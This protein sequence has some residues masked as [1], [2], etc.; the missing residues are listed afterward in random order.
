FS[1]FETF[2]GV[3]ADFRIYDTMLS[4][5]SIVNISLCEDENALNSPIIDYSNIR[6][7]YKNIGVEIEEYIDTN[8]FCSKK[9]SYDIIIAETLTYEQS[10]LLCQTL[11]ARM[12]I[13]SDKAQNDRFYKQGLPYVDVCDMNRDD[14]IWL[15]VTGNVESKR[16][17]NDEFDTDLNFTNFDPFDDISWE[18]ANMC[19]TISGNRGNGEYEPGTWHQ[20][21]CGDEYCVACQYASV[22]YLQVRG[23]CET[24]LFDRKFLIREFNGSVIFVGL[25]YSII[26]WVPYIGGSDGTGHG[27]WKMYRYDLPNVKAFIERRSPTHYPT[28]L[29]MWK[30]EDDECGFEEEMPLIITSC[31]DGMFSC[32]DGSCRNREDRCDTEFHCPEGTDELE[33][34][35]IILSALYDSESPPPR[36]GPRKPLEIEVHITVLTIK[37]FQIEKFKFACEIDMKLS[38][39]D[40]RLDFKNLQIDNLLNNVNLKRQ[41]PW[42]PELDIVSGDVVFSRTQRNL[43]EVYIKR[44]SEP[45]EDSDIN[46]REDELFSSSSNYL[47]LSQQLTVETTCDFNLFA[48]PFDVQTCFMVIMLNGQMKQFL[49]LTPDKG[50]GVQF[51]GNKKLREYSLDSVKMLPFEKYNYTGLGIK[52]RFHNLFTFYVSNTYLPTFIMLIIGY[53][54]FIFP[55]DDFNDRI[56]V[57]LTSLLVEAA[58]FTQ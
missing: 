23:L 25:F 57:A 55:L 6:S 13:P 48:F 58:L 35:P 16:W 53:M 22:K 47:V 50:G 29:N 11:G 54:T 45:L 19:V 28:G 56:M 38:W 46:F 26:E 18:E 37:S 34:D 12:S 10:D 31:G 43:F 41:Q 14:M 5:E 40:E 49:T 7:D 44:M 21:D 20:T 32:D 4:T 3:I 52:L 2:R 51:I 33:C 9:S 39:K 8:L 1:E 17:Y 24:S 30:V 36:P 42:L 27:F 15:G